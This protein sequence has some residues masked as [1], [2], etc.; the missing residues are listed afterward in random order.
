MSQMKPADVRAIAGKLSVDGVFPET[1]LVSY[2]ETIIVKPG[3]TTS[4]G[5]ILNGEEVTALL[6]ADYVVHP[7]GIE[8]GPSLYRLLEEMG[9]EEIGVELDE[10]ED[11][12]GYD[13]DG[14]GVSARRQAR[15]RKRYGKVLS[16]FKHCRE[17]LA[18]NKG[19]MRTW[20]KLHPVGWFVALAKGKDRR[21]AVRAKKCDRKFK[22]LVKIWDKMGR[23]GV[24]KSGLLSPEKY[25]RYRLKSASQSK[26]VVPG[27]YRTKSRAPRRTTSPKVVYRTRTVYKDRPVYMQQQQQPYRQSYQDPYQDP[28]YQQSQLPSRIA[29]PAYPQQPQYTATASA[30]A[31][32]LQ[33]QAY[34][35]DQRALE[36]QMANVWSGMPGA[37]GDSQ[38]DLVADLRAETVG[39]LNGD[40]EHDYYGNADEELELVFGDDVDSWGIDLSQEDVLGMEDDSDVLGGS[41][42]RR[43]RPNKKKRR[44]VK[45]VSASQ[46]GALASSGPASHGDGDELDE[47]G[48]DVDELLDS[49]DE[50]LDAVDE[51]DG[52]DAVVEETADSA[53]P[54]SEETDNTHAQVRAK[55]HEAIQVLLAAPEGESPGKIQ[56]ALQRYAKKAMKIDKI[57]AKRSDTVG[58]DYG[59][60]RPKTAKKK[61]P[62]V[63]VIAI[64]KRPVHTDA[65]KGE[66]ALYGAEL[67][68]EVPGDPTLLDVFAADLHQV[69]HFY[70][71]EEALSQVAQHTEPQ[72]FVGDDEYGRQFQYTV[73]QLITQRGKLTGNQRKRLYNRI[74]QMNRSNLQQLARSR[75]QRSSK[76]VRAARQELRQRNMRRMQR[77]EALQQRPRQLPQ[78]P[79]QRRDRQPFRPH[80]A[81][82]APTV[83]PVSTD[84]CSPPNTHYTD[85]SG[86]QQRCPSLGY[87]GDD[88]PY[89]DEPPFPP[90]RRVGPEVY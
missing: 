24:D 51:E 76:L 15:I 4:S 1:N 63:L 28:Y 72:D 19:A 43:R 83:Q 68:Y 60:V 54:D 2:G 88:F 71:P 50:D 3:A 16:R 25:V 70:S 82:Q 35:M 73:S 59:R 29:L 86:Y 18:A 57:L 65:V 5:R 67:G 87:G 80:R 30:D 44:L 74:P 48:A 33:Q 52:G 40:I 21:V 41:G 66:V 84:P 62:A 31:K 56:Q 45:K 79:M 47:F 7:Q 69:E 64:K 81:Q 23:K 42:K 61:G 20:E 89:G 90:P 17:L 37:Y 53:E 6:G 10:L 85:S 13:E 78:V 77:S 75:G 38:E 9:G 8:Y 26:Y 46:L 27:A 34:H 32:R 55:T 36:Q 12:L 58:L 49:V 11:E 39:Y 22:R 14:F